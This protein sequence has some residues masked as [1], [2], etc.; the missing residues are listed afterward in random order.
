MGQCPICL[1]QE[2]QAA[3]E[4]EAAL[5]APTT[6]ETVATEKLTATTVVATSKEDSG[7][8][9][10]SPMT[11]RDLLLLWDLVVLV[12]AS[13]WAEGM[14]HK[15]HAARWGQYALWDRLAQWGQYALWDRQGPW[16]PQAQWDQSDPPGCR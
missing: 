8:R 13:P 10:S 7:G 5:A 6:S 16:D 3:R 14:A 12:P 15:A 11:T 9:C 4:A 1:A 2:A